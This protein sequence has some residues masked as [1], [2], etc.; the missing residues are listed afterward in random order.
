MNLV[1]HRLLTRICF[2]MALGLCLAQGAL[3]QSPCATQA[4]PTNPVAAASTGLW[5][6]VLGW[7]GRSGRDSEGGVGGTGVVAGRPGLGGT[8]IDEGGIGGTGIVGT[9]TGFASIC[10][11]GVEVQFDAA[12][13]VSD[14]GQNASARQLAVGQV[15][16][17]RAVGVD[18][19]LSARA[20]A[21]LHAV[22]GPI[23]ELNPDTGALQILGQRV[24]AL[25]PADLAGLRRGQWVSVSG[26]RT[27]Q[28]E[29]AASLIEPLGPRAPAQLNGSVT[30][31]AADHFSVAGTVVRFDPAQ[32]P[33]D[34]ASGREVLVSGVW[35]GY[36]LHAQRLLLEPTRQMLGGV[37]QLVLEGYVHA[38]D[39]NELSLGHGALRL[40]P[41]VQVAGG[42][43]AQL[44][45]NQRVLLSAR[46][47]ADQRMQVERIEL[48]DG[49]ARPA[50]GLRKGG[51][52]QSGGG[53]DSSGSSGS[54]D[55]GSSGSSGSGRSGGG[56]DSGGSG[57][58][59][60]SGGSG[61]GG[62]GGSDKGG[63]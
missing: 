63:T 6:T 43:R 8:G 53:D 13:P 44:V 33:S 9:I 19:R 36:S 60:G 49:K 50:G 29:I 55:S 7:L 14:N 48:R 56:D 47:G 62:S 23:E 15:V 37:T 38:I 35:D 59:G 41:Q 11:N 22:G 45:V 28:G 24:R 3:A 27:A 57:S 26:H 2:G 32:A 30:A 16:A 5:H 52:R 39:G 25:A 58:S 61:G 10:V 18:A 17:V 4:S 42:S 40:G 54:D 1:T 12:T 46:V 51:K 21:V 31:L 20:I 34:L